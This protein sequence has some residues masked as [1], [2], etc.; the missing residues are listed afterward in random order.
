[1]ADNRMLRVNGDGI[2][3]AGVADVTISG[4]VLNDTGHAAGAGVRLDNYTMATIIGNSIVSLTAMTGIEVS[5]GPSL[6]FPQGNIT[7]AGNLV[8]GNQFGIRTAG[9]VLG[10]IS[11]NTITNN[12]QWGVVVGPGLTQ[13]H[14]AEGFTFLDLL[15]TGNLIANNGVPFDHSLATGGVR[16]DNIGLVLDARGNDWGDPSGPY[17]GPS[18][19]N[20]PN[21]GGK[22][23]AVSDWVLYDIPV[24]IKIP[25]LQSFGSL[26]DSFA[27]G[28]GHAHTPGDVL[29]VGPGF[30][31]NGA[32]FDPYFTDVFRTPFALAEVRGGGN[33]AVDYGVCYLG[34][35]W[36]VDACHVPASSL[37]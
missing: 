12:S 17:A 24:I 8:T 29:A 5:G 23:N 18:H 2:D 34:D 26:L 22:G 21:P 11:G 33:F 14:V 35:M 28:G 20:K 31:T 10:T 37:K 7:I 25:Q 1:V 15:I 9:E 30:T 36:K 6:P 27:R 4:N 32:L 19:F 16:N 3:I 13:T